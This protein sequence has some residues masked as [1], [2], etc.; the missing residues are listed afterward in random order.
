MNQGVWSLRVASEIL[1]KVGHL[2]LGGAF[3]PSDYCLE[4]TSLYTIVRWETR[5]VPVGWLFVLVRHDEFPQA[6]LLVFI[7]I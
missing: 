5:I 3:L 6:H 1:L 7:D 4:L 2:E